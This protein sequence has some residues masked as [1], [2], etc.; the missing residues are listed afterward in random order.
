[1]PDHLEKVMDSGTIKVVQRRFR[2]N[3]ELGWKGLDRGVFESLISVLQEA[4][5]VFVP[6]TAA[7][8]ESETVVKP[9]GSIVNVLQ[10]F[11]VKCTS[12]LEL[13]RFLAY[14]DEQFDLD[15]ELIT[16]DYL[17]D[18]AIDPLGAI[19]TTGD[20]PVDIDSVTSSDSGDIVLDCPSEICFLI[21]DASSAGAELEDD[22]DVTLVSDASCPGVAVFTQRVIDPRGYGF[23]VS[24][25][26]FTI[27]SPAGSAEPAAAFNY[28]VCP[29]VC[30]PADISSPG[31]SSEHAEREVIFEILMDVI[32]P[33]TY[34]VTITVRYDCSDLNQQLSFNMIRL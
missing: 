9:D 19:P 12:D 18:P 29:L 20:G 10:S 31:N 32:D 8:G 5:F 30:V 1:V 21:R 2:G 25:I 14:R 33:D 22:S 6:R 16:I 4:S 17:A 34:T 13:Q 24:E 27:S 11:V 28:T 3:F 26:K 7:S 23:D 15:V